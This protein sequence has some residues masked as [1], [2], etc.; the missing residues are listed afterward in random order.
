MGAEAKMSLRNVSLSSGKAQVVDKGWK[1]GEGSV[2]FVPG[3]PDA[4]T[5]TYES[6]RWE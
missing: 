3:A 4:K 1:G 2:M 5:T 6:L